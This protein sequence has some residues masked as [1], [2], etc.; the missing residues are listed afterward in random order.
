[1]FYCGLRWIGLTTDNYYYFV[2]NLINTLFQYTASQQE[3]THKR[4]TL[5]DQ[6]HV[7]R[8]K[9]TVSL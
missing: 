4:K 5:I 6:V 9:I 3:F 8:E 2:F 7:K 1:M